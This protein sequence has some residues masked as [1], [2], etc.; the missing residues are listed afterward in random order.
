[1]YKLEFVRALRVSKTGT[2]KLRPQKHPY[3]L[4][5]FVAACQQRKPR[6]V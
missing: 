6:A 4:K 3:S 2:K 1:M 5:H